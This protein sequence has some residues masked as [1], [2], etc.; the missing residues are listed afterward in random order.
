MPIVLRIAAI[1][2]LDLH[3]H[4]FGFDHV[5]DLGKG[6]AEQR[7]EPLD[8][9]DAQHIRLGVEAKAADQA[10]RWLQEPFF[11]VE[12]QGAL[13]DAGALRDLADLEV[14]VFADF[15]FDGGCSLVGHPGDRMIKLTRTSRLLC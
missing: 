14:G 7:L 8:L 2:G 10:R 15:G 4:F 12:A 3:L 13:G 5:L 11:F 9:L 6:K 1:R